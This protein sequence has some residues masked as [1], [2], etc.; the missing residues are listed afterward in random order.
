MI[1]AADGYLTISND[2]TKIVPGHGPLATKA[3]LSEYREML[4][5]TRDRMAALIKDGKSESDIY[6]AKPFADLDTK[7]AANEQAAGNF[8]RVVYASL[9]Q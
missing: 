5:I 9:K 3:Q 6:A 8:M 7:W 4:A 1:A 2:T